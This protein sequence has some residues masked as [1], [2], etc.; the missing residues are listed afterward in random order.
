MSPG[1]R[2]DPRAP[3]SR[4]DADAVPEGPPRM[5]VPCLLPKARFVKNLPALYITAFFSII[6]YVWPSCVADTLAF[7]MSQ[8][9]ARYFHR[10]LL[11]FPMSGDV[12]ASLNKSIRKMLGP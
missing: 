7:R 3:T 5:K 4:Q 2:P 6:A 11:L 10:S 1:P 8:T 12:H 9:L